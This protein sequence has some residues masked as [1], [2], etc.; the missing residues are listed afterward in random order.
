MAPPQWPPQELTLR[1]KHF[2][3]WVSSVLSS[4]QLEPGRR[5][6]H[7]ACERDESSLLAVWEQPPTPGA[8]LGPE[9]VLSGA[10]EQSSFLRGSAHIW[11]WSPLSQPA[12]PSPSPL[13]FSHT[14]RQQ[15]PGWI[16]LS[17]GGC[18]VDQAQLTSFSDFPQHNLPL[19]PGKWWVSGAHRLGPVD[20]VCMAGCGGE[21]R[22]SLLLPPRQ[23][24]LCLTWLGPQQPS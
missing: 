23:S 14:C 15:P 16:A 6:S 19:Q 21:E 2:P 17:P 13:C 1:I 12:G 10:A 9:E 4:R 24:R 18:Q 8:G 11:E 5:L 20:T 3:S 22:K 7:R